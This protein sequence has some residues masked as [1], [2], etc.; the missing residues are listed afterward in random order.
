MQID[1]GWESES[2][3]IALRVYSPNDVEYGR[4]FQEVPG[5]GV[6]MNFPIYSPPSFTGLIVFT[7]THD[8]LEINIEGDFH[9][10][11]IDTNLLI[12]RHEVPQAQWRLKEISTS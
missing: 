7:M 10:S 4:L 9:G 1:G 2:N 12:E 11:D 8:G 3:I 5:F 6:R